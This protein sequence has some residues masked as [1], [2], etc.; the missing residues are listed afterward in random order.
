MFLHI[1]VYTFKYDVLHIRYY[2]S[3]N[4]LMQSKRVIPKT[5]YK[6]A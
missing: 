5:K 1:I 4:L 2:V 3:Q 6:S